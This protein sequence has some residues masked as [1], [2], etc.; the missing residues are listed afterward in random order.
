MNNQGTIVSADIKPERHDR[1]WQNARRLGIEIIKPTL[2]RSDSADVPMGPFDAILVDVPC[3]NT[4]VLSKR[5][6]ARW[7]LAP[8]DLDELTAL[9]QRL[10]SV[11][12]GRLKAGGRIVYSTCSIEPAE[13]R[14]VVDAVIAAH[15]GL[16][17]VKEQVHAPGRPGD[18]AYQA[19]LIAAAGEGAREGDAREYKPLPA[20][21]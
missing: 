18:G 14:Q 19:L 17:L 8:R 2:I 9:Q 13:N 20:T 16:K 21:S 12:A 10:L 6:E 15:P 11:A 1:I 3:S 7:R 5:P 4:G